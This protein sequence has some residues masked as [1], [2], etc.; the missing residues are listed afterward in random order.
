MKI[1]LTYLIAIILMTYSAMASEGFYGQ[2]LRFSVDYPVVGQTIA[3]VFE[4]RVNDDIEF[5]ASGGLLFTLAVPVLVDVSNLEIDFSY[6]EI[7]NP[8]RYAITEFN[9]Y[10]FTD[11]DRTINDII[12]LSYETTMGI[13]TERIWFNENQI[14][15]NMSGLEFNKDSKLQLFVDFKENEK[16]AI[17]HVINLLLL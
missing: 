16:R 10:V 9:G 11:I 6:E 14:F 17:P 8:G 4:E 13:D 5:Q 2:R 12:G 7:K 3:N 1:V 15:M